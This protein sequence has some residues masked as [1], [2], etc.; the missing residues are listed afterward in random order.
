MLRMSGYNPL[1]STA[2]LGKAAN[3]TVTGRMRNTTGTASVHSSPYGHTATDHPE[4]HPMTST[5]APEHVVTTDRTTVPTI[6][7]ASWC[8]DGDGHAD[9]LF[10]ED[11]KCT[12]ESLTFI[13][14][15]EPK[16]VDIENDWHAREVETFVEQGPSHPQAVIVYEAG[17]EV[18]L[19]LTASEARQLAAH[20]IACADLLDGTV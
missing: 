20:L 7:C 17:G 18:E 11:Q 2:R 1:L 14:S 10:R 12:S 6:V 13:Q 3:T 5:T 9:D 15:L 19:R 16:W 4:R 8:R